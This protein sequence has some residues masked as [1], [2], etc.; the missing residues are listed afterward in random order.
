MWIGKCSGKYKYNDGK[1]EQELVMELTFNS[2]Y[3]GIWLI[4]MLI[5]KRKEKQVVETWATCQSCGKRW[6]V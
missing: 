4:W 1:Q 6:K 2:L 3:R 5:R